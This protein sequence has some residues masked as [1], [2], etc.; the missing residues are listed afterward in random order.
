MLVTPLPVNA[1]LRHLL[2][3]SATSGYLGTVLLLARTAD[4]RTQHDELNHDWTSVHDVTG[5]SLAVLCPIAPPDHDG[6]LTGGGVQHP[7]RPQ[8]AGV[9]GMTL[10][11]PSLR[12]DA[13]FETAFWRSLEQ[14][15]AYGEFG[16]AAGSRPHSSDVHERGWT[17]ATTSAA[18]FFGIH[19]SLLPCLLVLSMRERHGTLLA[20]EESL[21]VYRLFRQLIV[22]MGPAPAQLAELLWEQRTVDWRLSRLTQDRVRYQNAVSY[23]PIEWPVQIDAL[24]R[25][26]GAVEHLAPDLIADCR[27]RLAAI[28]DTG[29]SDRGLAEKL[30]QVIDVLPP[31]SELDRQNIRSGIRRRLRRVISKLDNG[32]P[33]E[34]R[35]AIT[36]P[37]GLEE[38]PRLRARLAELSDEITPLRQLVDELSLSDAVLRVGQDL[39]DPL[40]TQPL[41]PPRSLHDWSF[42]YLKRRE[43]RTRPMTMS[44]A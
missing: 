17:R 42:T 31:E 25:H 6:P 24:G 28:R 12:D 43:G 11:L 30:R 27:G 20:V 22:H 36:R 23:V 37:A 19:E 18:A 35:P 16:Q 44:R 29:E 13:T 33:G 32:P 41:N 26:L 5:A 2:S 7:W 15:D 14:G 8:A 34:G 9:A 39:L 10:N 21:S 4:A 40:E 38:I 3:A 1:F